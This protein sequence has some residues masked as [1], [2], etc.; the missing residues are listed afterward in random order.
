MHINNI[1]LNHTLHTFNESILRFSLRRFY[2]QFFVVLIAIKNVFWNYCYPIAALLWPIDN[3]SGQMIVGSN[4]VK[5]KHFDDKI[6]IS[7]VTKGSKK[8]LRKLLLWLIIWYKI[9]FNPT[10]TFGSNMSK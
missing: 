8:N 4:K 5:W 9:C 3:L 6:N 1:K 7:L 2:I 10:I